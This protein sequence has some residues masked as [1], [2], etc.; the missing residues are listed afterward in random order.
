VSGLVAA[1]AFDGINI[2]LDR[3]LPWGD[4]PA[5]WY[6]MFRDEWSGASSIVQ[7]TPGSAANQATLSSSPWAGGQTWRLEN[8]QERTHF[9]WGDGQRV[10]KDFTLA[11][12]S[13]KG[14]RTVAV[15]GV[16]YD[17]RVYE[18]TLSFLANPVP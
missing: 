11:T 1:V 8:T 4:V 15:Q 7:A 9:A 2:T 13:P 14:G 5:P 16:V 6:M 3:V 10:V 18:S 12:L 17:P